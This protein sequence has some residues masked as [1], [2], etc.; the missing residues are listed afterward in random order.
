MS[1]ILATTK[2]QEY[3]TKAVTN[4]GQGLVNWF[5]KKHGLTDKDL[6]YPRSYTNIAKVGWRFQWQEI[7]ICLYASP[8]A[9]AYFEKYDNAWG[10]TTGAGIPPNVKG[11][12]TLQLFQHGAN[13]TN[14]SNFFGRLLSRAFLSTTYQAGWKGDWP[15]ADLWWINPK[16]TRYE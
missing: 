12:V 10:I 1:R 8:Y 4:R 6:V 16:P 2:N 7:V 13:S 15:S 14:P 3:Y 5:A 11:Y 9:E